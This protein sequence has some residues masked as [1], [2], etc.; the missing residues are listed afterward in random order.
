MKDHRHQKTIWP[1]IMSSGQHFN[2]K[3][4]FTNNFTRNSEPFR[5]IDENGFGDIKMKAKIWTKNTF[6]S[7][8]PD[9]PANHYL[10]HIPLH[11][12]NLTIHLLNISHKSPPVQFNERQNIL[13][14]ILM[15]CQTCLALE[16]SR[17]KWI[18]HVDLAP[19][20]DKNDN[21]VS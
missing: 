8:F 6:A 10:D 7:S 21:L 15:L 2:Y 1:G 3:I 19:G 20:L 13:A 9:K 16:Q 18:M 17:R 4:L 5:S 11:I 12:F 14:G